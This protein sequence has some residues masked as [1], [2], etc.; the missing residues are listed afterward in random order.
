[1]VLKVQEDL[2]RN[3]TCRN[4]A[5]RSHGMDPSD[6]C[7]WKKEVLIHEHNPLDPLPADKKALDI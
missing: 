2:V 4:H 1:M 3:S 6:R 7:D 5:E